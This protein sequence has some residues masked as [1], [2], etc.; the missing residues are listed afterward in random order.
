VEE[1]GRGKEAGEK[2]RERKE[3]LPTDR[4]AEAAASI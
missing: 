3:P 2:E 1:E 4:T